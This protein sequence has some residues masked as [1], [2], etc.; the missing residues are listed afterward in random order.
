MLAAIW[1][2]RATSF[3]F[4]FA[5]VFCFCWGFHSITIPL[6]FVFSIYRW[7]KKTN[8]FF[9]LMEASLLLGIF[10]CKRS[11]HC[12]SLRS[13]FLLLFDLLIPF[14][15]SPISRA[16]SPFFVRSL[17][18]F[19]FLSSDLLNPFFFFV[20]GVFVDH[21]A[22]K[23]HPSALRAAFHP[24]FLDNKRSKSVQIWCTSRNFL[25]R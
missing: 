17:E 10:H 4:F 25:H 19:L 7:E 1:W 14:F 24:Y 9:L 2:F 21:L 20:L 18:S 5:D 15:C 22:M 11:S 3:F 13:F 8:W 12:Q 23:I 16:L 6:F